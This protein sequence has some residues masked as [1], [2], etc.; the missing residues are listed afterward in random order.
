MGDATI[1]PEALLEAMSEAVY[2]VDQDRRIT[3]WNRAAE[4]ITGFPCGEVVGRRC[5]DGILNH[6]DDAGELMCV[7]CRC[8][9]FATLHDGKTRRV[10]AY[11]HHRDGHRVPVEICAAAL[12]DDSGQITGAVEV[13]HDDSPRREIAERLSAAEA[14]SLLDPLTGVGNRRLLLRVLERR[15]AELDR[16]GHEFAVLF[17]DVDHFKAVNDTFG[18]DVG[19]EVL[20]LVANTLRH[21]VRTVDKVGRWGGEEFL[22]IAPILTEEEAISLADRV[23]LVTSS[24]WVDTPKGKVSVTLSIGLSVAVKG[25]T[26]GDALK[27][28]D[29]AMY[30]AKLTGR[31]RTVAG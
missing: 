13:F 20:Q 9:L 17:A 18:H 25:E 21:C 24:A 23:R 15:E 12:R 4:A 29:A 3:Y 2:V 8:P 22:I 16:Y 26:Y 30:E 1:R 11:L 31:N 28:A 19:D 14:V 27:R 6:V 5:R 10:N 7:D